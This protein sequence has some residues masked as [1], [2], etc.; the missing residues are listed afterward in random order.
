MNEI[1]VVGAFVFFVTVLF[2]ALAIINL[3]DR[4]KKLESR[5][6]QEG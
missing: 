6:P 1:L 3:G 2:L 4:V 5:A